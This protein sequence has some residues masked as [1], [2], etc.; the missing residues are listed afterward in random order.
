MSGD[1]AYCSIAWLSIRVIEDW[2]LTDKVSRQHAIDTR[3][4]H[5]IADKKNKIEL[6]SYKKPWHVNATGMKYYNV[7]Y[8]GIWSVKR[9][10]D[11]IIILFISLIGPYLAKVG[12][13]GTLWF[14]WSCS[15]VP[16][17]A[18]FVRKFIW[19]FILQNSRLFCFRT[20]RKTD[21]MNALLFSYVL[22]SSLKLCC[23]L[24]SNLIWFLRH[25]IDY[26]FIYLFIY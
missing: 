19:K 20:Q 3:L 24:G 2:C 12:P 1:M 13:N 11:Y 6:T 4:L 25:A 14:H 18:C 8:F 16:L 5:K 17:T 21:R 22:T 23:L 15:M 7:L 10:M 26:L 9:L